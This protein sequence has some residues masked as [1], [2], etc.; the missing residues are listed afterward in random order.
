M[1]HN[2]RKGGKSR[3]KRKVIKEMMMVKGKKKRGA[4]C[5]LVSFIQLLGFKACR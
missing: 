2:T 5:V 3:E 4:V 1:K